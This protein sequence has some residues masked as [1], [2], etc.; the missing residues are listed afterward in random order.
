MVTDIVVD[1][2]NI[3]PFFIQSELPLEFPFYASHEVP[4]GALRARD[5]VLL[6]VGLLVA[7]GRVLLHRRLLRR[8]VPLD[9]SLAKLAFFP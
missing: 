1:T 4:N 7:P 3:G 2:T 5:G 6:R 9:L 8:E